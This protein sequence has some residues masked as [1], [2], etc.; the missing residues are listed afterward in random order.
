MRL[1]TFPRTREP[2]GKRALRLLAPL[3][4][5]VVLEDPET[6]QRLIVD[7]ADP[8]VRNNFAFAMRRIGE[9]RRRLFKKLSLDH[10]ELPRSRQV[11]D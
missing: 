10:V 9:D 8:L 3:L 2:V 4:G 7:A 5:P 1:T 11:A 6:G